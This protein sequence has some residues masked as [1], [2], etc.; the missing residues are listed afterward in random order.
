MSKLKKEE[1]LIWLD[2]FKYAWSYYPKASLYKKGLMEQ[3]YN[4]IKEM[5][6]KPEVTE[7]LI[8]EKAK[9]LLNSLFTPSAN[10]HCYLLPLIEKFIQSF[11]NELKE[12]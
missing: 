5:I 7:E 1:L 11:V 8:E 6:K 2:D 4:Q 9:E 3:A 12:K 10:T